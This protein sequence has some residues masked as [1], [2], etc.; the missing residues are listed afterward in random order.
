MKLRISRK[1]KSDYYVTLDSKNIFANPIE[2]KKSCYGF[3]GNETLLSF[4][5]DGEDPRTSYWAPWVKIL[6][7]KYDFLIRPKHVWFAGTP[8]IFKT[9]IAKD[10]QEK[11][12]LITD[13]KINQTTIPSLKNF[14]P[15]EY[16]LYAYFSKNIKNNKNF[17][18]SP[19]L[20]FTA[21]RASIDENNQEFFKDA[22]PYLID[23]AKLDPF[24]VNMLLLN[25]RN[26]K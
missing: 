17:P 21:Y 10:I 14:F 4:D 25:R 26:E 12:D 22:I 2:I 24:Y 1:I 13:F 11:I 15:S 19:P 7:K 6:E 8:F 5:L 23:H 16:I 3:E 20:I 9:S 18:L